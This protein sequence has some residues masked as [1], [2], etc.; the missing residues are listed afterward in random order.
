MQTCSRSGYDYFTTFIDNKSQKVFVYGLKLKSDLH[1]KLKDFIASTELE[2]G[3]HLKILCTDGGR[4]Y[5]GERTQKYLRE[6]GIKHEMTT[7]D[8]PQHNGVTERM[9]CMLIETA[10]TLLLNAGLPHSF[11]F[12]AVQYMAY[13]H[14]IIP[15]CSL[16]QDITPKEAWSGN[17]P[18]IALV[19]VF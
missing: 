11:W 5:T 15:T 14:N 16:D 3:Q 13:L 10:H 19:R 17:R 18:N 1:E 7:V 9:N 4:E 2:T 12:E 8:T 6:R